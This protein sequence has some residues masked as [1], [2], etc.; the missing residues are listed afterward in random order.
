LNTFKLTLVVVL[1][2]SLS[3]CSIIE[4]IPTPQEILKTPIGTEA[5]KIGMTKDK[6]TDVWGPPDGVKMLENK[7]KWGGGREEWTYQAR[8]ALPINA[9]YLYK[10]QKL[11]FDGDNL[12]NIEEVK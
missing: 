7:E 5:V 10:T 6:V 3:G 2:L 1:F 9:G 12:T 4:T 8:T 11:Y